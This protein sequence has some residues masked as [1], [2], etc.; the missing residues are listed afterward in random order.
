MTK[1]LNFI[2]QSKTIYCFIFISTVFFFRIAFPHLNDLFNLSCFRT[3]SYFQPG[4]SFPHNHTYQTLTFLSKVVSLRV[5]EFMNTKPRAHVM[6]YKHN[7]PLKDMK[8]SFHTVTPLI[9]FCK[10][11]V[12]HKWNKN[13][14]NM[15]T[16]QKSAANTLDF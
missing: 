3:S 15:L 12:F 13:N 16:C 4:F 14:L 10:L 11:Q 9:L 2:Q 1:K 5:G 8:H 7:T 6:I